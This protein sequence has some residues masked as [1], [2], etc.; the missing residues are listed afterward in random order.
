M[1]H[2]NRQTIKKRRVLRCWVTDM[3]K[4]EPEIICRGLKEVSDFLNQ[5]WHWANPSKMGRRIL[6]RNVIQKLKVILT[7][8]L[9]ERQTSPQHS[10]NKVLKAE[11][12]E[13]IQFPR[14]RQMTNSGSTK[15]PSVVWWNQLSHGQIH[16]YGVGHRWGHHAGRMF[17]IS[18]DLE[19][20]HDHRKL[21]SSQLFFST[22]DLNK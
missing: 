9:R 10:N 8:N 14:K 2:N 7:E 21:N 4:R 18:R 5:N 13:K 15:H 20:Y 19:A 3:G 22:Q 1:R 17:V 6:L 11:W 12:P 16:P